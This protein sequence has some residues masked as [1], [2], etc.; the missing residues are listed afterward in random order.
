MSTH[1]CEVKL[2]RDVQCRKRGIPFLLKFEVPIFDSTHG[3]FLKHLQSYSIH[4]YP[5]R[6]S[7][8]EC[9]AKKRHNFSAVC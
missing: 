4:M 5:I 1:F 6:Q 3:S 2:T 7:Q 9:R 8:F